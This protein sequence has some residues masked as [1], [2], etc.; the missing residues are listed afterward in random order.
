MRDVSIRLALDQR[1]FGYATDR[2]IRVYLSSVT[3]DIRGN[4]RIVA[5]VYGGLIRCLAN[6]YSRGKSEILD[7][8]RNDVKSNN[9][10]RP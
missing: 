3:C 7:P 8:L 10:N 6:S 4:V 2:E 5:V 1:Q 9:G